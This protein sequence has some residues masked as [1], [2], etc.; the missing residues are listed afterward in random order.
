MKKVVIIN[1]F[2]SQ[3]CPL[4]DKAIEIREKDLKQIGIT[5]CFDVENNCVIDYDNSED[6][7]KQEIKERIEEL[8]NLLKETD[9]RAIKYA[10]GCYTAEEYQ[11]YKELRQSYRDEIN[12]LEDELND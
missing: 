7:R 12:Q 9:Y 6:L 2:N 1:K 8:K 3:L 10:E 4:D 5:K 11:P